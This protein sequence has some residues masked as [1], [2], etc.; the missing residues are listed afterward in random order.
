MQKTP[1][2]WRRYLFIGLFAVLVVLAG[3]SLLTPQAHAAGTLP[4]GTVP[5][6]GT[7]PPGGTTPPPPTAAQGQINIVDQATFSSAV[8][9]C[10][11]ANVPVTGATG[12]DYS[13]QTG[14]QTFPAGTY[15][16]K[17]TKPGCGAT[18]VD[19]PP[20]K[21]NPQAVL[22]LFITGNGSSEQ[23]FNTVLV[24]QNLGLFFNLYLPIIAQNL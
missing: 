13:D 17:V 10:T 11:E 12:L 23:P 19:I 18:I 14:F 22:T 4:S 16:W 1:P 15:D 24:V 5:P 6:G 3:F 7:I 21:L 9:V 8:D 2:F 20:F